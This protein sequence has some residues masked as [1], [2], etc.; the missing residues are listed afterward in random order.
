MISIQKSSSWKPIFALLT[1]LFF[2]VASAQNAPKTPVVINEIVI[3]NYVGNEYAK[4]DTPEYMARTVLRSDGSAL[5]FGNP[6]YAPRKGQFKGTFEPSYFVKISKMLKSVFDSKQRDKT[7]KNLTTSTRTEFEIIAA[8]GQ[9]RHI[10]AYDSEENQ[11]LLA[12][13]NTIYGV[14]WKTKWQPYT[15]I[16]RYNRDLS[17]VR[18]HVLRGSRSE[19]KTALGVPSAYI[20]PGVTLSLRSSEGKEIARGE[21]DR[22]GGFCIAAPPGTYDLVP[23]F[24]KG[25]VPDP[26]SIKQEVTITP[27][28]FT[29]AVIETI[30]KVE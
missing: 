19:V 22:A 25:I 7:R 8:D 27:N 18:G 6:T 23:I 15:G 2:S 20:I 11:T 28:A 4:Q 16:D 5:Y 29:D 10:I 24:P 9:K 13:N 1:A 12:A 21:S 17:G 26:D 3:T 30:E 14:T